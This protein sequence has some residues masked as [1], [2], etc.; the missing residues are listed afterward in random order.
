MTRQA[1]AQRVLSPTDILHA[2]ETMPVEEKWAFRGCTPSDT[3]KWT[4]DY[5]RYPAKFI[6]QLVE[7][8]IAEYVST[9]DAHVNDPFMGCG[10]TIVTAIA[11]GFH[12][13]GT[14]IN[15]LAHLITR[16]KAT[17]IEPTYLARKVE[18]FFEVLQREHARIEPRV[19][20]RHIER[21]R[22]WFTDA[23]IHD[24]GVLLHLIQREEDAVIRDFLLVA[25]SHILKRCSL[26]LQTSTKPTR[27]VRKPI[28]SPFHAFRQHVKKMQTGN[29]AFYHVVPSRV[30]AAL[31]EYLNVRVGDAR[32]QPV[33]DASVDLIVSSSP[34]VTSYEYADL[35]QLS[36]LWLDLADDLRAYR[37]EFIGTAATVY[38]PRALKSV[39]AQNI[40]A[41][42]AA[43]SR[44]MAQE[45]ETFFADMQEV[46]DESFRILKPGGRCCYVIGN[47]QLKGV[48]ILNAQVFAESLQHSGFRLDRIIKREIPSKILPQKRDKKTGRFA[49]NQ[50]ADA[51]AYPVEY[52]VIG[53]KVAEVP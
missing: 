6:P 18:A 3:G 25:F 34:Y 29:E 49:K 14:D 42:L 9:R 47:T 7:K 26:W 40:I 27:D 53:H 44:K 48:D 16:V 28:V 32:Q 52:I 4:H 39:L 31:N 19:P 51:E 24:L 12:A 13:S 41:Q 23:A 38:R 10:T 15:R 8:L 43:S 17:P 5:H 33:P 21:I 1:F 2:F 11:S 30:R 36:T 37:Q 46:F 22:Y 35:H 45:V 50:T 20:Q